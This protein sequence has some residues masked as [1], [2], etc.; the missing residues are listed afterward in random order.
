MKRA[1][2][3][4]LVLCLFACLGVRVASASGF[5]HGARGGRRIAL[6][7]D[8]GPHPTFTPK[9]LDLLEKYDIKATFFMI[10][11]NVE[12]YPAVAK[13][14]HL[15]GHEIGN[16]TFTHPH[17]KQVSLEAL[18]QEIRK[19]EAVLQKN[20]IPRPKLFR[21]PEGFRSPEQVAALEEAG[22]LTVIW[23]L[24]SHDWQGR[25][26]GEILSVVLNG[27]QGGDVLLFHDYTSRQNT[28]ITALEQLIPKLL[29]D[30]YEFV[31]I[32]DLMC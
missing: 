17:M 2:A 15:A 21:P 12:L 3:L 13:A 8:D 24:D 19:T 16:H 7:F 22:Y 31:T 1:T 5:S 28:T 10:G 14:V 20:G 32:S 18:E 11:C 23:S 4:L 6:S 9:I 30:G 29:E 27:V 25:A 26:V